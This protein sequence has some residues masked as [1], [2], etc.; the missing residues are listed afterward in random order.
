MAGFSGR[1]RRRDP[2][3]SGVCGGPAGFRIEVGRAD[4][5]L[6]HEGV[7]DAVGLAAKLEEAAVV[8]DAVDDACGHVV[9][10]EYRSPARGLEICGDNQ[11]SSFITVRDDLEPEPGALGI[12][13]QIPEKPSAGRR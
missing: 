4:A 12:D 7:F 3:S 9:V 1:L 6:F 8:H 13:R 2:R 11:A 5:G 10:A